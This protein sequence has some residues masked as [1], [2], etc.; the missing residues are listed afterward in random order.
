MSLAAIP[1]SPPRPPQAVAPSL[2]FISRALYGTVLCSLGLLGPASQ[3]QAGAAPSGDASG[4]EVSAL[5]AGQGL[6]EGL[7][8]NATPGRESE[9]PF[10]AACHTVPPGG[11]CPSGA[12]VLRFPARPTQVI[13]NAW[14]SQGIE[15][16]HAP[17]YVSCPMPPIRD[18][19]SKWI[20]AVMYID[21]GEYS[22]N[23]GTIEG[24]DGLD[25]PSHGFVIHML[26]EGSLDIHPP[27]EIVIRSDA[28][29]KGGSVVF[30]NVGP[31]V[32][33]N[34]H[35]RI[36]PF[37]D[38]LEPYV[39][40]DDLNCTVA[41]DLEGKMLICDP[42][43]LGPEVSQTLTMFIVAKA[44]KLPPLPVRT[45]IKIQALSD[46]ERTRSDVEVSVVDPEPS[47]R[48]QRQ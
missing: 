48:Q 39:M 32:N 38:Y 8:L 15:C 37:P 18:G 45:Y 19:F 16:E 35:Y 29:V 33:R 30:H 36:G 22:D 12:L 17:Y 10:G 7:E 13:R 2:G 4:S 47:Q 26:G 41:T 27:V 5:G 43:D 40:L 46:L 44:A 25:M 21:P 14:D 9:L 11:T 6:K 20:K 23:A 28:R 31:S 1:S 42:P 3:A 24:R 34:V